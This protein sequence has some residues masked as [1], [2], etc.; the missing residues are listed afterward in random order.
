[1]IIPVATLAIAKATSSLAMAISKM[2]IAKTT[3]A[4]VVATL[5]MAIDSC[6]IGSLQLIAAIIGSQLI[7]LVLHWRIAGIVKHQVSIWLERLYMILVSRHRCNRK[8][9]LER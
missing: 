3:L 9:L 8:H 2:S 6:N 1:M 5:A 7:G 4:I